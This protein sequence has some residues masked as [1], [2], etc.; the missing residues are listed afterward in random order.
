MRVPSRRTLIVAVILLSP[1]ALHAAWDQW[2]ASQF[3]RAFDAIA[4]RHE[5]VSREY[6]RMV[7]RKPFEEAAPR[8]ERFLLRACRRAAGVSD[9]GAQV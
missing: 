5:P 3:A 6:E 4:D 8:G 7:L 1:L 2:E 9:E